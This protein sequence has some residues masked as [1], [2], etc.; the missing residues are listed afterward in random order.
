MK[1]L[2]AIPKWRTT[3]FS[4]LFILLTTITGFTQAFNPE[5]E[6]YLL[7]RGDDIGSSHAANAGC[8]ASY[9]HGIMRSVELMPPCPWFPEAVKMLQENPG[10]NVG[11]HLTLTSEWEN[12][13]WGPLTKARSISDDDGYFYPMVWKRD[14]FPAHTSLQEA[15]WDIGEIEAELRAQIELALKYVPWASHANVHME[16]TGLDEKIRAVTDRLIGEYGLDIEME[17]FDF[18]RFGGWGD[19]A[20]LTERI[21]HF[22]TALEQ[23][24]PGFYRFVDHPAVDSPEMRSI[25]HKGYEDVAVDRDQVTR[26]FTSEKVMKMIRKRGIN[27]ISYRDLKEKN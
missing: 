13:K 18:K 14:D 1:L 15:G 7:V 5:K 9:Q 10:L 26:V 23:L 24:E 17:Q 25:W 16:A 3:L 4:A 6:I 20:T 22:C 11:I 8:M 21:E 2:P 27:L 19:A 12:V